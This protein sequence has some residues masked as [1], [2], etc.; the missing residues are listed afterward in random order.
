MKEINVKKASV[1]GVLGVIS[2]ITLLNSFTVVEAGMV[3]VQTTFGVINE[4][5]LTEGFHVVNPFSK[6]D[7]MDTRVYKYESNGLSI[8]TQD[9]FNSSANVTVML[10]VPASSTP[11]IK[12]DFGTMDAYI[13]KTVKQYLNSIA[14]DEGRKLKDSR[15]L[16]DSGNVSTMQINIKDR[17]GAQL[18][19][20]SIDIL[21]VLVQEIKFDPRIDKQILATQTR[22]QKEE[23]EKSNLKLIQTQAAQAEA[24]AKGLADA[25]KAKADGYAYSIMV[26]ADAEQHKAKAESDAELYTLTK[27]AEGNN[28]LKASLTDSIIKIKELD[29]RMKEAGNGW[30]GE[31]PSTF[32]PVYGSGDNSA[33]FLLKNIK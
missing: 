14:R 27:R 12:A 2:A 29:V 15:S 16:A 10:R 23:T 31:L 32:S 9:R 18:Q 26:K 17:L 6:L 1:I 19:D 28:K 30:N 24:K 21:E 22:I 13:D 7:P 11:V 5:P 20:D 25:E 3:K 8:P 33:P 4:V